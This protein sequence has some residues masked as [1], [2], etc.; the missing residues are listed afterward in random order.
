MDEPAGNRGIIR[1]AVPAWLLV[2]VSVVAIVL[3]VILFAGILAPPRGH[4]PRWAPDGCSVYRQIEW[5]N[6]AVIILV[7]DEENFD[8]EAE[9][10]SVILNAIKGEAAFFRGQGTHVF[11]HDVQIQFPM[12]EG[13]VVPIL[14]YVEVHGGEHHYAVLRTQNIR[15]AYGN[16]TFT[17]EELQKVADGQLKL[18]F[19]KDIFPEEQ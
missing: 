17:V 1:T 12:R 7:L 15:P 9:C 8:T 19:L 18:G 3:I 16:Y 10:A 4:H 14:Q 11:D 13:H 2:L 6:R 5:P